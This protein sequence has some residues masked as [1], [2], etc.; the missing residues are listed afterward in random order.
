MA[1]LT[2]TAGTKAVYQTCLGYSGIHTYSFLKNKVS[3]KAKIDA[4]GDTDVV[5]FT[6]DEI[7]ALNKCI[8]FTKY[9]LD[10][11][12]AQEQA[13][14]LASGEAVKALIS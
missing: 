11:M 8:D 10:S 12:T 4:A 3:A 7:I 5:T 6:D 14:V 9:D 1:D 13:D 2:L